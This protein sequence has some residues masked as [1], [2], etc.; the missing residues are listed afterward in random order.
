[1]QSL[2]SAAYSDNQ[3]DKVNCLHIY[4]H[5]CTNPDFLECI[6]RVRERDDLNTVLRKFHRN[7][8]CGY[9]AANG[10]QIL[11]EWI[12]KKTSFW[13]S[14][15][16]NDFAFGM[17]PVEYVCMFGALRRDNQYQQLYTV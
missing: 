14:W 11:F 9:D 17:F 8:L 13:L 15:A 7:T 6:R 4:W 2:L 16:E 5:F 10:V 1:M 3:C 12:S